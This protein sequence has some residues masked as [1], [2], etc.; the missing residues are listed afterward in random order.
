MEAIKILSGNRQAISRSLTVIDVWENRI[1]QI[2]LDSL[3]ESAECPC[4]KQGQFDWLSGRNASQSA[5]LCGRNAVQLHPPG[6]GSVS[7][8]QLAQKLGAVGR[9]TKNP[10]LVRAAIDPYVLTVFSDGRAIVG[11][12]DDI[13]TARGI[14]AKYIGN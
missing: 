4:C 5:I 13:S 2:K 14:Y 6:A 8:E 9:V 7:L 1:R 12:T 10:F 3:R 11:G